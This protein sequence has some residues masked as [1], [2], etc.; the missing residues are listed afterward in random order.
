ME[1]DI[2]PASNLQIYQEREKFS[3]GIDSILLS[4]FA[5]MKKEKVVLDIG[6]GSGILT[7]RTFD[8]Y[9]LRKA[10]GVEIQKDVADLAKKTVVLNGLEEKVE[11]IQGDIREVSLAYKKGDFDYIISNPPY[12]KKGTGVLNQR[13]NDLISR[14]EISLKLEDIFQISNR[15]LNRGA[16]LF[17]VH[18]PRRI[19]EI[20][21]LAK[22]SSLTPKRMRLVQANKEKKPNMVLLEFA[23]DV[24]EDF[25]VENNLIVYQGESYS[26]EVLDI[27]GRM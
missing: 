18:R 15:L 7:F 16:K 24:G 17:M 21:A 20:F 23:K 5:K 13:E 26:Q 6:C 19:P 10:V 14:Q 8:L 27:Y 22:K 3:Y 4:S 1:I 11:I 2:I 25:I 9:K 12:I